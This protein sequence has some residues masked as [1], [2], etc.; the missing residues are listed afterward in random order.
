MPQ[1]SSIWYK[2]NTTCVFNYLHEMISHSM[3]QD[4]SFVANCI[5]KSL[6]NHL[7]FLCDLFDD[8]GSVAQYH[9]VYNLVCELLKSS[10]LA[11]DFC[12][13]KDT[14]YIISAMN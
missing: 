10:A 4:K 6:Y 1:K 7:C 8:D 2:S 12:A 5:R 14:G 9:G 13:N 3:Y 11:K